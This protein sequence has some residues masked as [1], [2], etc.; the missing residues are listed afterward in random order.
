MI[1]FQVKNIVWLFNAENLS[2]IR[3]YLFQYIKLRKTFQTKFK[4][5]KY[6]NSPK[7]LTPLVFEE[8]SFQ[9]QKFCY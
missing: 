6:K 3:K 8:K 2:K 4:C 5:R 7:I 9:L 1:K